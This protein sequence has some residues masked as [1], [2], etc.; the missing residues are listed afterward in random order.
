MAKPHERLLSQADL[1]RHDSM[2]APADDKQ[3]AVEFQLLLFTVYDARRPPALDGTGYSAQTRCYPIASAPEDT[4]AIIARAG[5][6][7]LG[8]SGSAG[9]VEYL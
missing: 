6:L 7:T 1:K 2:L 5:H 3:T 8:Q 4:L 9:D